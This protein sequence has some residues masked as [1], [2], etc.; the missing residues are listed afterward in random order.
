[1]KTKITIAMLVMLISSSSQAQNLYFG[2]GSAF[3]LSAGSF[4]LGS[5]DYTNN[6]GVTTYKRNKGKG[7]LGRGLQFDAFGGYMLNKNVSAELGL[8]YLSGFA[9]KSK[10]ISNTSNYSRES[11][12]ALKGTSIR[13]IPSLKF[14]NGEGKLKPY[15]KA[16]LL[17]GVISKFTITEES[18]ET[19]FMSPNMNAVS[20][21]K[22]EFSGGMSFGFSG[23][24]GVDIKIAEKMNFFAEIQMISHDYAPKR[25][26]I[27]KYVVNGEDR[28]PKMDINDKKIEFV[29]EYSYD[30]SI[31]ADRSQ[32]SKEIKA[33]I[34]FSSVGLHVGLNITL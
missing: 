10:D 32:P 19:Y 15:C 6:N 17:I 20:E 4:F 22:T 18:S 16:G 31:P 7:S 29:D 3:N 14:S 24:L 23:S 34:P 5:T 11:N 12:N 33:F 1:M 27:T 30:S 9:N 8:A 28:L 2:F 25:A 21:Q 13:V 26:E